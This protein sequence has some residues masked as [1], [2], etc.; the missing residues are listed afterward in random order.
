[1]PKAQVTQ[2]PSHPK[3]KS[4]NAQVTQGG[5]STS[6]PQVKNMYGSPM[7]K[8]IEGPALAKNISGFPMTKS[9]SCPRY[10]KSKSPKVYKVQLSQSA[11]SKSPSKSKLPKAQVSQSLTHPRCS[12]SKLLKVQI[13][14]SPSCLKPPSKPVKN[15]YGPPIPKGIYGPIMA[16][17]IYFQPLNISINKINL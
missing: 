1:M 17:N 16:Q 4:P 14:Q 7:A 3:H 2:S 9:L 11:Q 10:T 5:S 13:T 8:N 12:K 6:C 15:S